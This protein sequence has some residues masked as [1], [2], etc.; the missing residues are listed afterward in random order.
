MS[1]AGDMLRTAGRLS[2]ALGGAQVTVECPLTDAEADALAA[3]IAEGL[4]GGEERWEVTALTVSAR[5]AGADP[6]R[7]VVT[8][9]IGPG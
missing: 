5:Q 7:L 2:A 4:D 9:K 3:S 1:A 8:V 6:P